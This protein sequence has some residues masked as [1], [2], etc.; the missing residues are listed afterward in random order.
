MKALPILIIC[1]IIVILPLRSFGWLL[2]DRFCKS[3]T[4]Y[5]TESEQ[6]LH[7]PPFHDEVSDRILP[8]D[9]PNL[10]WC[11]KNNLLPI[12]PSYY[13]HVQQKY[14][15]VG[16]FMYWQLKKIPMF[17]MA[18]PTI[19]IM[20]YGVMDSVLDVALDKRNG[21]G[22]IADVKY[23]FP[24]A[25]HNLFLGLAGIFFYNVEVSLLFKH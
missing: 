11:T 20:V 25:L 4:I 15:N 24:F 8:G 16:V 12:F 22:I 7:I 18:T 19:I 6:N 3:T 14:W 5:Y 21:A 17:L 13:S 2:E 1:T 10:K 9:L 23:L